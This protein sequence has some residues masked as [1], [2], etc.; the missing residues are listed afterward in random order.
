MQADPATSAPPVPFALLR[1]RVRMLWLLGLAVFLTA[2]AA[3]LLAT[4]ADSSGWRSQSVTAIAVAICA[5]L[6][7]LW[8]QLRSWMPA[9]HL[10]G[11]LPA[12]FEQLGALL[13]DGV[14][15]ADGDTVLY[16]NPAAR[17]ILGMGAGRSD[18]AI[19]SLTNL[20][21][22][23]P[24]SSKS[25]LP[26]QLS[27][28]GGEP[29]HAMVI[30]QQL[31]HDGKACQLFVIRD[32]SELEHGRVALATSNAEL[33]AMAGRLFSLQEDERRSISRDLHDDIGQA[34]T[35]MKLAACAARDEE[36]KPRRQDDIDQ[37]IELADSTVIKLRNLSMLLRP[38]QLDAL[39]LEAAL[40]WQ[41][42]L[43][44]RSTDVE[45]LLDVDAL[46]RRPSNEVE[47]ACFR[48]AQESLTNALRHASA[49][50]VSLSLRNSDT[51]DLHLQVVDDGEG[52]D[53]AGPRGLGMI[54]MRERA[55]S[56]GGSLHIETAPGAGTRIDLRLP[57]AMDAQ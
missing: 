52:F 15:I 21:R 36:N 46:P 49:S 25:E 42:G 2:G 1:R 41:A 4:D 27:R 13:H 33:Q 44:F 26:V 7:L 35:A 43:L 54:V 24:R 53:P 34:I 3:V 5:A 56:A 8:Y 20:G 31:H 47:Q 29:F 10:H 45:L 9:A 40:R 39:G 17:G 14:V 22:H 6:M 57:Y 23:G 16:A 38:P 11:R 50:E 51:G 48:I 12:E 37:I 18:G 28:M 55:Q 32:L 19:Q 30:T